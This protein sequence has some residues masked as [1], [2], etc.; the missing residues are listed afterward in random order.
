MKPDRHELETLFEGER[1]IVI[2]DCDEVEY[3]PTLGDAV[4]AMAGMDLVIVLGLERNADGLLHVSDCSE[5]LAKAW[6]KE[7]GCDLEYCD[8]E[9]QAPDF[10][11]RH[12]DQELADMAG[13][14]EEEAKGQ[15]ELV[16]NYRK[17][18]L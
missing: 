17:A 4:S 6:L 11:K 14:I 9:V 2:G 13:E 18:A 8:G 15:A 7:H 10:I 12:C 5:R 16:S 3:C 1:F